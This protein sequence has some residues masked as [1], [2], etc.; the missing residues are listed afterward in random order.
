MGKKDKEAQGVKKVTILSS[1]YLR[2][3]MNRH[4]QIQLGNK[5]R[6]QVMNSLECPYRLSQAIMEL[7]AAI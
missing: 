1:L 4:V 7:L 3:A 2:L 5:P 6:G